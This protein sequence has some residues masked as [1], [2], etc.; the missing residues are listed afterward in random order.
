MLCIKNLSYSRQ[1]KFIFNDISLSL[2]PEALNTLSG[3]SGVGKTSFL[4]VIA[5]LEKASQGEIAW[6][7][8][9]LAGSGHWTPPWQRPFGMVFQDYALWPH[10]TVN[11]HLQLVQTSCPRLSASHKVQRRKQLL[12]DFKLDALSD[13]YP[14]QLSGGQQQRLAIARSLVRTPQ[15]LL[16]DEP[17]AHVDSETMAFSWHALNAWSAEYKITL[18]MV[19]H[20]QRWIAEHAL[21]RFDMCEGKVMCLDAKG[22]EIQGLP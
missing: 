5:G 22:C 1:E 11:Q 21:Q 7:G 3:P 18:L 8:N 14:S 9:I 19:S 2:R 16:L 13:R 6:Q 12:L 10:L 15:L 20:D 17:F 4:R